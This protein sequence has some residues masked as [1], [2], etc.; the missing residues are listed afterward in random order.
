MRREVFENA[1]GWGNLLFLHGWSVLPKP[2]E[3]IEQEI[4]RNLAGMAEAA[5]AAGTSLAHALKAT[6]FL[7]DLNDRERCLNEVWKETFPDSPPAR[8]CVEAGSALSRVEFDL[9][10]ARPDPRTGKVD[11][12]KVEGGV[13]HNGL[14]FMSGC[15]NLG[16]NLEEEIRLNFEEIGD[17]LRKSGAGFQDVVKATV[18]LKDLNDRERCLNDLWRQQFPQEP[19]A[20]TC[21]EAGVGKTRVEFD[22]IV[23]LPGR[24]ETRRKVKAGVTYGGLLFTSG[25]CNQG[26]SGAAELEENFARL[27]QGLAEVGAA[28][29]DVVKG[30]VFLSDIYDRERYVDSAWKNRFPQ[31]PPARTCIQAGCGRARNEVELVVALPD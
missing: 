21:V 18:Y 12:D 7:K 23:G 22:F 15:C 8:T 3:T 16:A 26:E 28:W 20:R 5:Q 2:G 10:L 27:G 31:S 29:P 17:I 14:F 19:P 13:I 6:V 11:R 9:I 4:R 30:T 1:V 25:H 24:G